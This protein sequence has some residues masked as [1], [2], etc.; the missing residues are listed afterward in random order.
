M[1]RTEMLAAVDAMIEAGDDWERAH[2]VWQQAVDH[3]DRAISRSER[4][5]IRATGGLGLRQWEAVCRRCRI[6]TTAQARF[7]A[8]AV[9]A[10]REVQ[11]A[12]E[13][14]EQVRAKENVAVLA[15][16]LKL[17][18]ATKRVLCYRSIGQQLTA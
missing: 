12:V 1:A 15:A 10:R 3:R 18:E 16:R 11:M 17:A 4:R 2:Q 8:Q 14:A 5:L 7:V 6:N 13:E 9:R